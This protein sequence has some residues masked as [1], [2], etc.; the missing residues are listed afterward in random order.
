[1]SWVMVTRA[2]AGC[3]IWD[4]TTSV[5]KTKIWLVWRSKGIM[6]LINNRLAGRVEYRTGYGKTGF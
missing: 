4:H 6:N 3:E 1:M 2:Q 5:V